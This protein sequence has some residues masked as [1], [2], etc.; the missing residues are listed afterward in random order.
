MTNIDNFL[1]LKG[2]VAIITGAATGLGAATAQ[3]LSE[4]GANVLIN[5]MPGQEAQAQAVANDCQNESLCFA[6]DI[7]KDKDCTDMVEA[8]INQWRRVDI[9][10]NNAGINKP[11]EHYDLD[12]LSAKDFIDIYSVNVIGAFQMIR[13]VTPTMNTQG[14]GVVVNVSSASGETGYGSSVAYSASKGALNTMT[15]SLG[16]ALA[17]HI[18]VNAVCPGMVITPLWDKLEQ[19][20]EQRAAWLEAVIAEIPLKTEP[21]PEI[22]ARSILFLASDLS[23]HLTGQLLTSDGGALLGLYQSMFEQNE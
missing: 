17:P 15:K 16:R 3:M 12:G 10:I 14:S 2:K 5:H 11:V 13:A 9:L 21:T 18:R 8:V 20:K 19:T 1:N 22:V 6:S 23:A 4:A 7:T